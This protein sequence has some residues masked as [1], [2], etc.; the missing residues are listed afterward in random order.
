MEK[1]SILIKVASILLASTDESNPITI[2]DLTAEIKDSYDQAVNRKTV[3]AAISTWRDSGVLDIE[4]DGRR[5]YYVD[6]RLF[7]VD[8]A[9][10]LLEPILRNKKLSDQTKKSLCRKILD[11]FSQKQSNS[12]KN[13]MAVV[14]MGLGDKLEELLPLLRHART[15][16]RMGG[17]K[18]I[19]GSYVHITM[20]HN[21]SL[22]LQPSPMFEIPVLKK[23]V[24]VICGTELSGTRTSVRLEDIVSAR[25]A[26]EEE[27]VTEPEPIDDR[28]MMGLVTIPKEPASELP[29]GNYPFELNIVEIDGLPFYSIT[30]K[31]M[32]REDVCSAMKIIIDTEL[33]YSID[34]EPEKRMMEIRDL[35]DDT[36]SETPNGLQI[37]LYF[38][39]LLKCI[40]SRRNQ[41]YRLPEW[42]PVV[43]ASILAC[44]SFFLR[45][46]EKGDPLG[47]RYFA[48]DEINSYYGGY[49]P[50]A[51]EHAKK[52]VL[53]K[54]KGADYLPFPA[55]TED[56]RELFSLTKEEYSRLTEQAI[57]T[58]NIDLALTLMEAYAYAPIGP[59]DNY[60]DFKK[61]VEHFGPII[62]KGGD[63]YQVDNYRRERLE[64][65]LRY[66]GGVLND[67]Y[68]GNNAWEKALEKID[69]KRK[70]TP[71]L[72]KFE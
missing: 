3:S 48:I 46:E 60:E 7:T 25:P 44:L 61:L 65:V 9:K 72:F 69:R 51:F 13:F 64:A 50:V 34:P 14:E 41:L 62:E 10:L 53:D 27:L 4:Q 59:D 1:K 68:R 39:N 56:N 58:E 52:A 30:D 23:G 45:S 42:N 57:Q 35:I 8:E 49:S 40:D 11:T 67:D 37:R 16:A 19:L 15:M 21:K 6:E 2:Q 17:K 24:P 26:R 31:A 12:L 33:A 54:N 70:A 55:I 63:C 18:N 28:Y 43:R 47:N 32:T 66:L 36:K 29:T 38:R 5:G 22:I 20:P 71:W